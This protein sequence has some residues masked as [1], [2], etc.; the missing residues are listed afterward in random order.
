MIQV[1][2][3]LYMCTKKIILAQRSGFR[4]LKMISG[5]QFIKLSFSDQ[6]SGLLNSKESLGVDYSFH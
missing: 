5:E 2:L 1:N 3:N 4:L 6:N